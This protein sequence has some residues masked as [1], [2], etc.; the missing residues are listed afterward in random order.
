[1]L[2]TARTI[3]P[4][5]KIAP[6]FQKGY[7][8]DSVANPDCST[9]RVRGEGAQMFEIFLHPGEYTIATSP[10]WI[11]ALLGPCVVIALWH[12]TEKIGT[13]AHC[14]FPKRDARRSTA[15][16]VGT[17]CDEAIDLMTQVLRRVSINV[18]ECQ[19]KIFGGDRAILNSARDMLHAKGLSVASETLFGV[20]HRMVDFEVSSGDV[21][22]GQA[23]IA[24]M[25]A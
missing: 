16:P 1:M 24:E 8:I 15:Q 6:I 2:H 21:W 7:S 9:S 3:S 17:Y 11:R 4:Q 18:E 19:A 22:V 10:C 23:P 5:R 12:P 14:L 20:G 25:R 13:M